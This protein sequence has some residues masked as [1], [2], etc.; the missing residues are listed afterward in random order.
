MAGQTAHQI[1]PLPARRAALGHY[2]FSMAPLPFKSAGSA[3]PRAE[4]ECIRGLC[5]DLLP[6]RFPHN[7]DTTP[8]PLP[9]TWFSAKYPGLKPMLEFVF[10]DNQVQQSIDR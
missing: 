9:P 2:P 7:D 6:K 4:A 3:Q 1:S 10:A 8:T 5:C